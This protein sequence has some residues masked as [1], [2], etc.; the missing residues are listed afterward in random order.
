MQYEALNAKF[1]SYFWTNFT[2]TLNNFKLDIKISIFNKQ[3]DYFNI[4]FRFLSS[5]KKDTVKIKNEL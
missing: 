1:L 5:K 4:H 3:Y 2:L